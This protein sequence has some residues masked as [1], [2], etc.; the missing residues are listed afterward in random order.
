M[1]KIEKTKRRKTKTINDL[2]LQGWN[3]IV[4]WECELKPLKRNITLEN[5]L[6]IITKN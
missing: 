3:I 6:K 4:L 1:A 2:K 5:V